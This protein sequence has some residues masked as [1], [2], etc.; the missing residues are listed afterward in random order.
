M[1]KKFFKIFGIVF[2]VAI[3]IFGAI[4]GVM[5]LQGKFKQPHIEPNLLYFDLPTDY[6]D[7]GKLFYYKDVT[8]YCNG[9]DVK[10][11]E[12]SNIYSFTLK[13]Q[14]D[15]TTELG[16]KMV[17]ESGSE[18]ITVCNKEGEALSNEERMNVNI[19]RPVYFKINDTFDNDVDGYQVANGVVK[20]YFNSDNNLR[21][22]YLTINIDRNVSSV[23]L[24]DLT[25][26]DSV[27]NIH[28]N[29][30]FSYEGIMFESV[31]FNTA[32]SDWSDIYTN[33][34]IEKLNSAVASDIITDIY[35][36]EFVQ[37]GN[38]YNP[39]TVYYR[40]IENKTLNLEISAN[41]TYPLIPIYAPDNSNQP[42]ETIDGKKCDI[43]ILNGTVFENVKNTTSSLISFDVNEGIYKF[44]SREP[45]E[46]TLYL[47]TYPTYAKQ[48]E[49]E[50]YFSDITNEID[51]INNLIFNNEFAVTKEVK[52]KVTNFGIQSVQFGENDEGG[53]GG[54]QVPEAT[55]NLFQENYLA[56]NKNVSGVN[57]FTDMQIKM[58]DNKGSSVESRFNQITFFDKT[59][60]TEGNI[61]LTALSSGTTDGKAQI[62]LGQTAILRNFPVYDVDSAKININGSKNYEVALISSGQDLYGGYQATSDC[63][64]VKIT[65]GTDAG[66]LYLVFNISAV[67]SD[68][69]TLNNLTQSV[70][71]ESLIDIAAGEKFACGSTVNLLVL[72]EDRNGTTAYKIGTIKAG[73]YLVFTKGNTE[74][75]N[76][77]FD[78][79]STGFGNEKM[80][81]IL[82]KESVTELHLRLFVVNE[83]FSCV[84]TELNK[85][86]A[87]SVDIEETEYAKETNIEDLKVKYIDGGTEKS[88]VFVESLISI[89]EGSYTLPLMFV[90]ENDIKVETL[91]VTIQAGGEKYYLVGYIENGEFVNKIVPLEN[92]IGTQELYTAILKYSFD[93]K[94][95]E[96][97]ARQYLEHLL[98][99]DPDNDADEEDV[100]ADLYNANNFPMANNAVSIKIKYSE[101]V[102]ESDQ[103]PSELLFE[104]ATILN[105]SFNCEKLLEGENDNTFVVTV[106]ASSDF[107]NS[108]LLSLFADEAKNLTKLIVLF[109]VSRTVTS[110]DPLFFVTY[111]KF[112]E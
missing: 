86:I 41:D 55:L 110:P 46:Y 56:V 32:P 44:T 66:L 9:L 4:I 12:K 16:C 59:Y 15:N 104:Q 101:T 85:S 30:K 75:H 111:L 40:L 71:F 23:S 39:G 103:H 112:P 45:G 61:T 93:I 49:A 69:L 108:N 18:L 1:K 100:T 63:I 67:G 62:V 50:E 107:K 6:D 36:N 43:Y 79:T 11:D 80:F 58:F 57:N 48:L 31:K 24:K 3:G 14:P 90:K 89:N 17:I 84:Y 33:Y 73:S 13:A 77:K 94:T 78:I 74:N 28:K 81:V 105:D 27:N 34:Y 109:S 26:K 82:P 47:V 76:N 38:S 68:L 35:G 29:G 64:L 53:F 88:E 98:D 54:N 91:N 60:F 106:A 37:A 70:S 51:L 19:N 83:D 5:A 7:Q 8:Y 97:L 96:D 72:K 102:D 10:G 95:S 52:I 99:A 65:T 87:V 20:I 22:A 25:V 92:T 21:N 42:L 2:G